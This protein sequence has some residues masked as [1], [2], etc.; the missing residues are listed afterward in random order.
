MATEKER[1]ITFT[2]AGCKGCQACVSLAPQC[3]GW[4]ED[5]E[6]PVLIHDCLPEDE[7]QEVISCCPE[8]CIEFD[9]E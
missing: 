4:D 2:T 7:A 1:R 5:R 6:L 3:F 8:D 9:D